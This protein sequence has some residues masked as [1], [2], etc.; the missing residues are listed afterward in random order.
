MDYTKV[1][2]EKIMPFEDIAELRA[3]LDAI[4]DVD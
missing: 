3:G 2:L 4:K 1:V